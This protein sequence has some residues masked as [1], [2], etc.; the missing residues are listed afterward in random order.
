MKEAALIR[1]NISNSTPVAVSEA[2]KISIEMRAGDPSVSSC[3]KANF[4]CGSIWSAGNSVFSGFRASC[5][6]S[7]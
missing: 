2:V 3:R 5:D 7:R 6:Y 4:Y 1:W